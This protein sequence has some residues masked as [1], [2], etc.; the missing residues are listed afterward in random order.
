VAT[1]AFA[2]DCEGNL[3]QTVFT[4]GTS[5][6]NRYAFDGL[7][8]LTATASATSTVDFTYDSGG[9]LVR[10]IENGVTNWLVVNHGGSLQNVL[11]ELDAAG[12]PIRWYLWSSAGLLGHVE[13]SGSA[14]YYHSDDQGSVV[15][16]TDGS[17]NLTDQLAYGPYGQLRAR[18]GSTRLPFAW[19]ADLGVREEQPDL[20]HMKARFYRSDLGRFIQSD[21]QGI[22]GGANLY[23]YADGDPLTFAD[24]YGLCAEAL[25]YSF[26][27]LMRYPWEVLDADQRQTPYGSRLLPVTA[28]EPT[29]RNNWKQAYDRE[30]ATEVRKGMY[31]A[32]IMAQWGQFTGSALTIPRVSAPKS[33]PRVRHYTSPAGLK[34]IKGDMAI[35]PSRGGGVHVETE[36]F[37]PASTGARETGA[38]G[39]GAHV[40]FDAPGAMQPTKAG[41]RNTAV[42]PSDQP[43][44][45]QELNPTF[46]TMPWWKFWE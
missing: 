23:A 15:A 25:P 28:G 30:Y 44:Q 31:A 41:P 7:S 38:F 8:R 34:G 5:L 45:I 9:S 14:R 22:G 29:T 21:P 32:A 27:D 40:E 24:P 43:V 18:T 2:H 20:Y 10:R 17:G 46:K 1:R 6:T 39:R 26:G 3:T 33:V 13:S 12:N 11:A 35:N 16:V 42:I 37:G 36:P 4:V 19:L